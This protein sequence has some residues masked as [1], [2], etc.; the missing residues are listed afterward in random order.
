MK[1]KAQNGKG[2]KIKRRELGRWKKKERREQNA[3][4]KN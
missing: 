4:K 3:R 2:V 1:G